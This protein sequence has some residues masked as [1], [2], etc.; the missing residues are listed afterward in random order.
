MIAVFNNDSSGV[1]QLV[2]VLLIR[3]DRPESLKVRVR[4][5]HGIALGS[6]HQPGL[7]GKHVGVCHVVI[8]VVGE[9][10]KVDVVRPIPHFRQQ[11]AQFT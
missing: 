3:S 1:F 4:V 10:K 8:V 11:F 5:E 7:T 2:E 6:L 9:G